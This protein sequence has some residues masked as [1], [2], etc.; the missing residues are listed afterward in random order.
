M[1]QQF[2]FSYCIQNSAVATMPRAT[3]IIWYK[4]ATCAL[5][6]AISAAVNAT[7]PR[8]QYKPKPMA[9]CCYVCRADG[10]AAQARVIFYS[11]FY[12]SPPNRKLSMQITY[13]T[14]LMNAHTYTHTQRMQQTSILRSAGVPWGYGDIEAYIMCASTFSVAMPYPPRP[15]RRPR[16]RAQLH[17]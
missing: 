12:V 2:F 5:P 3:N 4:F 14:V 15:L 10:M 16:I 17:F 7:L 8:C 11:A 6:T 1:K 9:H 13:A